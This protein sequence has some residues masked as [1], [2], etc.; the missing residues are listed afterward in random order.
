MR[1]LS[2]MA[3]RQRPGRAGR[4]SWRHWGWPYA[5]CSKDAPSR[6][7]PRHVLCS[8]RHTRSLA[9]AHAEHHRRAGDLA[10]ADAVMAYL[11]SGLDQRLFLYLKVEDAGVDLSRAA[12]SLGGGQRIG[13]DRQPIDLLMQASDNLLGID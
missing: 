8:G 7:H 5:A 12:V 1:Y 10:S 6:A 13:R 9:D 2:H 3:L 4:A 11:K